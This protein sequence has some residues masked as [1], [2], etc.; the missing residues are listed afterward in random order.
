MWGCRCQ[1]MRS[2]GLQYSRQVSHFVDCAYS[3]IW[4]AVA[5]SEHVRRQLLATVHVHDKHALICKSRALA[6]GTEIEEYQRPDEQNGPCASNLLSACCQH[7]LQLRT[8]PPTIAGTFF[9]FESV[10]GD[11]DGKG[12]GDGDAEDAPESGDAFGSDEAF[13]SDD[14]SAPVVVDVPSSSGASLPRLTIV[15]F[16]NHKTY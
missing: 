12:S 10:D 13:E 15:K 7:N 14:K 8:T 6:R 2:S 9:W 11:G 16:T 1:R 4:D 3:S 5:A